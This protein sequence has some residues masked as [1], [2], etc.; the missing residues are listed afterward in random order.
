[1]P[2]RNNYAF[3]QYYIITEIIEYH[4]HLLSEIFL[5]AHPASSTHNLVSRMQSFNFG[6]SKNVTI[7][8]ICF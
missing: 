8:Q 1:M 6:G 4:N 3:N 7:L 2:L 5:P